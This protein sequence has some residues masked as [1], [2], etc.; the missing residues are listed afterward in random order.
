MFCCFQTSDDGLG[1]QRNKRKWHKSPRFN[2]TTPDYLEKFISYIPT[3]IKNEDIIEIYIFLADYQKFA[4]TWKVLDLIMEIGQQHPQQPQ[5]TQLIQ[6][7]HLEKSVLYFSGSG[8]RNT[9]RHW[10]H[11]LAVIPKENQ[12]CGLIRSTT[13]EAPMLDASGM[14][15]TVHLRTVTVAGPQG[16]LGPASVAGP[17]GDLKPQENTELMDPA[18]REP[19]VPEAG[20][21]QLL[22]LDQPLPTSA[23]TQK[24]PGVAADVPAAR[25]VFLPAVVQLGAP[26]PISPLPDVDI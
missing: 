10:G 5:L 18:A 3:A 20:P 26:E 12:D 1:Y 9:R 21:V 19:T 14:Q 25:Q 24:P 4:I 22:P 11:P 6:L 13:P 2:P 16:D 23:D 17:Q 7:T 15:K 8:H